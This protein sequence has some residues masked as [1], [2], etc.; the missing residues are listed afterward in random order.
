M[1][2]TTPEPVKL[3]HIREVSTGASV[4]TMRVAPDM[5]DRQQERLLRGM[6]TNMDRTRFYVDTTNDTGQG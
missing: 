4:E 3:W 1:S 6:L 2:E 5:D